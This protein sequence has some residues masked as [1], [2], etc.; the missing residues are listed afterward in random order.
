[1]KEF[2]KRYNYR[3]LP[4]IQIIVYFIGIILIVIDTVVFLKFI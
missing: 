2:L 3:Q 1:M 4:V